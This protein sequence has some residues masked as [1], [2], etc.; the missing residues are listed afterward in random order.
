MIIL[1][2]YRRWLPT[3][4]RCS[5]GHTTDRSAPACRRVSGPSAGIA[6]PRAPSVLY[7]SEPS[8]SPSV[9]LIRHVWNQAG[10]KGSPSVYGEAGR[11]QSL[12]AV[13]CYQFGNNQKREGTKTT[14]KGGAQKDGSPAAPHLLRS[15]PTRDQRGIPSLIY[16]T[17]DR[18]TSPGARQTGSGVMEEKLTI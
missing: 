3:Q 7:R 8:G 17:S 2:P 12:A 15:I 14:G 4:V 1:P 18:H 10:C 11:M 16:Q 13:V 5:P 6:A 9:G